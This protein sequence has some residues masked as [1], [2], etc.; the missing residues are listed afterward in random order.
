MLRASFNLSEPSVEQWQS[1][2]ANSAPPSTHA[3]PQ[4]R[5]SNL[6]SSSLPSGPQSF[7]SL[8]HVSCA[9]VNSSFSSPAHSPT[10]GFSC[11]SQQ[12]TPSSTRCSA[13]QPHPFRPFSPF[14]LLSA[15]SQSHRHF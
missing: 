6:L 12:I 9:S 2:P 8:L 3:S 14:P 11:A 7:L 4:T 15:C 13:S 10:G 1:M 5:Y